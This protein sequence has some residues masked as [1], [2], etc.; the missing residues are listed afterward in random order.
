MNSNDKP[1]EGFASFAKILGIDLA[2]GQISYLIESLKITQA[3]DGSPGITH[4]EEIQTLDGL[5]PEE[6]GLLGMKHFKNFQIGEDPF[7]IK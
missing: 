5:K 4:Q 1:Q 3:P 6:I 7:T 2:E